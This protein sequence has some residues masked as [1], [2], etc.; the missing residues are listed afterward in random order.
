MFDE[1]FD[2]MIAGVPKVKIPEKTVRSYDMDAR[3]RI[4][5]TEEPVEN[6]IQDAEAKETFQDEEL[7]EKRLRKQDELLAEAISLEMDVKTIEGYL[8]KIRSNPA[9]RDVEAESRIMSVLL[10]RRGFLDTWISAKKMLL[11]VSNDR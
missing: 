5:I 11:T 7:I 10:G 6:P 4:I 3:G 8:T 1:L 2:E 9:E